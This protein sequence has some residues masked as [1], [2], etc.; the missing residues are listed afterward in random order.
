MKQ[1]YRKIFIIGILLICII[2]INVA[3]YIQITEKPKAEGN[4]SIIQIDATFLAENFNS[5]FDN[6][7]NAQENSIQVIKEDS[8]QDIIYTYY[9]NQESVSDWYELNVHIPFI[10]IKTATAQQI[11]QEIKELF[12][13]KALR[14]LSN[15]T[16][17]TAYSV[18]YKAYINDN[19]LSLIVKATLKEG[20]NPQRVIIKT[21]NYNVSSENILKIEEILQYRQIRKD[22]AQKQVIETIQTASKNATQLRKLGYNVFLRDTDSRMYQLE[23][24]TV[25]FLGQDK[26]LYMIYA[27]GNLNYTSEMDIV[28]M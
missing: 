26:A 9:H 25:Y 13:Q 8:L 10:N 7:C 28:V 27:Y 12:Y 14:I 15:Q 3:V 6:T 21:Y 17:Y 1:N 16:Q 20:E 4:K 19:I 5:I 22:V 2:A 23:N 11:N 24:T 18:S